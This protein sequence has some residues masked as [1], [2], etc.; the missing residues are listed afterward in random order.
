[1]LSDEAILAR[2]RLATQRV[3][4]RES[5][6]APETGTDTTVAS[7]TEAV[8]TEAVATEAVATEAVATETSATETSATEAEGP[9]SCAFCYRALDERKRCGKCRKRAYCTKACQL[10]DWRLADRPRDPA[11][12]GLDPYGELTPTRGRATGLGHWVRS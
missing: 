7:A 2:V 12:P 4:A 5:G 9:T 3:S 10:A 8:A 6:R 11:A 1:M